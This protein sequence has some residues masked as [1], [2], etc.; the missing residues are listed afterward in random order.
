MTIISANGSLKEHSM[1][2]Y[3]RTFCFDNDD[4]TTHYGHCMSTIEQ[5]VPHIANS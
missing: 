5:N 2:R 3:S 4:D 1:K